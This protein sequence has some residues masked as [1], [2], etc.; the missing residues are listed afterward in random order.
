MSTPINSLPGDDPFADDLPITEDELYKSTSATPTTYNQQAGNGYSTSTPPTP[1]S[2]N[3]STSQNVVESGN[4]VKKTI[5]DLRSQ[6]FSKEFG[7]LVILF[8]L[9]SQHTLD[10]YLL[11][12]PQIGSIF[13][14]NSNLK[15]LTKCMLGAL[16]FI[17]IE[18]FIFSKTV[19]TN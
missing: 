13:Y 1:Q 6:L 15:L 14:S 7:I 19:F 9:V 2:Q 17:L 12:I 3:A 18:Y 4:G 11:K 5:G 16:L 10:Y 8:W